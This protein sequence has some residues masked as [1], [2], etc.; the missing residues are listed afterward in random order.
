M[1]ALLEVERLTWMKVDLRGTVFAVDTRAYS[2][3]S[4]RVNLQPGVTFSS[5]NQVRAQ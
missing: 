4:G 3:T 1:F 2:R 5:N